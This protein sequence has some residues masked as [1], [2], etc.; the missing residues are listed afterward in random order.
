MRGCDGDAERCG[1]RNAAGGSG[2]SSG[3]LGQVIPNRHVYV[4]NNLIENP[5]P[6]R[7]PWQQFDVRGPS[8]RRGIER[9]L[10]TQVTP[11]CASPGT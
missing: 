10:Q 3:D 2:P 1:P 8:M 6:Y 5:A 4:L 11:T 9:P 7:S